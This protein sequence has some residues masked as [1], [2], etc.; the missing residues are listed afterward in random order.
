MIPSAMRSSD[1]WAELNSKQGVMLSKNKRLNLRNRK[2]RMGGWFYIQM[3]KKV[4]K[5]RTIRTYEF[6]G[7]F[8]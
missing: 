2:K 1:S 8:V 3:E 7:W 6:H 4:K 5:I